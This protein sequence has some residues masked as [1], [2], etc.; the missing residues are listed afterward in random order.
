MHFL[1]GK[2]LPRRT[3]LKGMGAVVALPREAHDRVVTHALGG[4][5]ALDDRSNGA[6]SAIAVD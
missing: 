6:T 3:F 5:I 4:V 1:T 2:P